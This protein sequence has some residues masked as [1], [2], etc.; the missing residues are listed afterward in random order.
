[1]N[2]AY[3][4]PM[5]QRIL[6]IA[7]SHVRRYG[8]KRVTI[9]GVA[10]EL[11]MTHAN[12]YRYFP[13]KIAL[14]DEI[15]ATWLKALEAGLR[16]SADAPDPAY[17]K[18][19][20][21]L[22]V[23]HRTYRNKFESDPLIFDLFAESVIEGRGVA[24]KHRNQV[25]G[26]L[27]RLVEEGIAGGTFEMADHR[28]ALALVFDAMHRFIHPVPIRMDGAIPRASVDLRVERLIRLVSRAI[29]TGRL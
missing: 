12:V 13:S 5:D 18:L 21:V 16:D 15:T 24:R 14:F 10:E 7:A 2:K 27:Q 1:M 6:D 3:S 17:D 11:D 28:R 4:E 19:E 26:T 23:L 22:S 29:V 8:V 25:Q 9:V 20:R